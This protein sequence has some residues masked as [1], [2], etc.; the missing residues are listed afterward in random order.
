[1]QRVI[2][3]KLGQD[4]DLRATIESFRIIQQRVSK[5]AF[6]AG[7]PRSA[8]ELHQIAYPKVRGELKSQLTC[9]AIRTVASEYTRARRRRRRLYGEIQFSK[10]RALFLVGKAKR[11]ACPPRKETIRIWTV[12]GR[13]DVP[14]SIPGRFRALLKDVTSYDALAVSIKKGRLVATL[15]VTLKAPD[16]RGTLPVGIAVGTKNEVAV[17][18]SGGK[19]LRVVTVAQSVMEE[20]SRKTKKRL[21]RRLAARKADGRE[22]RSVRRV[23]KRLSRRRHMRMKAFSHT[24]ANRIIEWCGDGAI[25][26]IEDLRTQSPSKR[27]RVRESAPRP[28]FY[29]ALRRRIEEKAELAAIPVRYVSVAGDKKRCSTC[30]AAGEIMKHMFRCLSCGSKRPT[31]KNAA[32]NVRNKFTVT[33]PWA[34]VNQP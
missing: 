28:P 15:S 18:D 29:E 33:R 11:D 22:T 16:R 10:P 14:C 9:T 17:V 3:I 25:V 1:M 12:A 13:K 30:G 5:I 27:S 19:S 7:C 8:I 34:A 32:L 31:S 24:A 6:G 4:T 21:E 2:P 23:L 26:V 20:T